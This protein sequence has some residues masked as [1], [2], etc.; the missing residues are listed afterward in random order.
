M[1]WE[2]L[3]LTT[4][5]LYGLED[6]LTRHAMKREHYIAFMWLYQSMG[7]LLFFA[8]FVRELNIPATA[9]PWFIALTAGVMWTLAS[10]LRFK[11]YE[12]T[13]VS[14]RSPLGKVNVILILIMSVIFLGETLTMQKLVGTMLIFFGAII[15]VLKGRR[16]EFTRGIKITFFSVFFAS[17]AIII[18]K[19]S[20]AYFL[21]SVYGFLQYL[22]PA[23]FITPLA[24]QR[25]KEVKNV[26]AKTR[27]TLFTMV[28]LGALG[29]FATLSAFK[30]TDASNV[31][32]ITQ[33]SAV[34]A[35]LG[36]YFF[37]KEKGI[38]KRLIGAV[39]MI[40]GSILILRPNLF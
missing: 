26:F 31:F 30:L 34:V 33:L 24:L 13:D 39:I 37:H 11:S 38:G 23:I 4:A 27:T 9:L 7:G 10:L 17:I 15:L 22:L 2:I 6:V 12:L 32:P 29:Y 14:I 18:D 20:L 8:L 36:G 1:A 16:I 5:V 3:A 19:A 35:V 25:K 28:V 40:A 21:P